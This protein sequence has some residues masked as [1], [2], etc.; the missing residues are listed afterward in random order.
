VAAMRGHAG[1][2]GV[3]ERAFTALYFIIE[4]ND[5]NKLRARSAGAKASAEAALK[6]HH[7]T[8]KVVTEA[9]DLLQQLL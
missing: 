6:T 2:A 3:Q 1:S 9:Q 8:E 5:E 4:G 7:A